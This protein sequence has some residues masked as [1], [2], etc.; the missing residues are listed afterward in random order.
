VFSFIDLSKLLE[1]DLPLG[2]SDDAKPESKCENSTFPVK[3]LVGRRSR[4]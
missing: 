1:I 4:F 3:H 2:L